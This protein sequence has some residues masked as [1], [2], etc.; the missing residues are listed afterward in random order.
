MYMQK[1]FKSF[2]GHNDVSI[3]RTLYRPVSLTPL[4]SYGAR[5]LEVQ[6]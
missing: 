5:M 2:L 3:T 6:G 1:S 4:R